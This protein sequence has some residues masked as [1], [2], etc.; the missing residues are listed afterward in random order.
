M[1]GVHTL[2]ASDLELVATAPHITSTLGKMGKEIP[3]IRRA[4]PSKEALLTT[5]YI[6]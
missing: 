6:F 5:S 3:F 4:K 1:A 2:V